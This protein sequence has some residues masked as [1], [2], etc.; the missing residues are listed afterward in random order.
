MNCVGS[1][2]ATDYSD[3]ATD[4]TDVTSTSSGK[5]SIVLHLFLFHFNVKIV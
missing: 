4:Y 1:T 2:G 5:C 3:Y